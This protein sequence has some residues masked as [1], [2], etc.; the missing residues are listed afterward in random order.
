MRFLIRAAGTLVFFRL[1]HGFSMNVARG[2][3]KVLGGPTS[4]REAIG[5]LA[6]TATLAGI[7]PLTIKWLH[8]QTETHHHAK[9]LL[10]VC[11]LLLQA[12][13]PAH[14]IILQAG[15]HNRKFSLGLQLRTS[16][17]QLRTPH[18]ICTRFE[19][20]NGY[21]WGHITSHIAD[22]CVA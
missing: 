17:D 7:L 5:Q 13:G 10:Y 3:G 14:V 1:V 9:L 19:Y 8:D 6:K 22:T 12:S 20:S 18:K 4:R 16:H 2:P 11:Q 21:A 15:R